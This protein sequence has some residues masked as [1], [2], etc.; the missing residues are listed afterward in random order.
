MASQSSA[1]SV[2]LQG[3]F[4]EAV[5]LEIRTLSAGTECLQTWIGQAAKLAGLAADTL[6]AFEQDKGSLSNTAR[7][8]AKFGQQNT[9]VFS[10]L[11]NRMSQRYFEEIDRLVGVVDAQAGGSGKPSA[12]S[13]VRPIRP[14]KAKS[15]GKRAAHA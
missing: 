14:K 11:S 1:K 10:D 3:L 2:D 4:A 12:K 5:K 6:Q 7:A 15:A 8:L 13:P 9:D